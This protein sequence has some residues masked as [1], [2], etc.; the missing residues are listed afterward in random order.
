V[1]P[2][3]FSSSINWIPSR[4]QEHPL[5]KIGDHITVTLTFIRTKEMEVDPRKPHSAPIDQ[6]KGLFSRLTSKW[7]E[8]AWLPKQIEEIRHIDVLA[9]VHLQSSQ[10]IIYP[11]FLG[12]HM[13]RNVEGSTIISYHHDVEGS[14]TSAEDLYTRMKLV[15][16]SVYW[17]IIINKSKDP[18]FAFLAMLWSALYGWDQAIE[19]LYEHFS[20]LET[21]GIHT[22]DVLV[23]YELHVMR[24]HLLHYISLLRDFSTSVEFVR[25][26]ANPA[27]DSDDITLESRASDKNLLD[28]ECDNLLAEVKRLE[29]ARKTL[30]L[31][32]QNVQKLIYTSV[33]IEDS[34]AMKRL[35]YLTM[36]F[37]P[38]SFVAN[39]FGMNCFEL[40]PGGHFP[41]IRFF[42]VTVPLTLITIWIVVAFQN[43]LIL[44]DDGNMW[45]KFLWPILALN[46]LIPRFGTKSD[47]Y[48][49]LQG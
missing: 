8:F 6:P 25:K 34:K 10:K 33:N 36:L 35:S 39:A 26:T 15:G 43:R 12:I 40:N 9:P 7:L 3:F 44:R 11:D 22:N 41:L 48:Q 14:T 49:P 31:R 42:E 16:R 47:R 4:Y 2:F 46:S 5:P 27:M 18:T 19:A 28:K 20:W 13:V 29:Q 37:L 32:V 23:T 38:A 21:R 17:R 30:D 24:A 1:E 45:K